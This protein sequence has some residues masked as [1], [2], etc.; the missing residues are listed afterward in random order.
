ML[1]R[2]APLR[3]ARKLSCAGLR[4]PEAASRRIALSN[5][6]SARSRFSRAFCFSRSLSRFAWSV[7]RPPYSRCQ[8]DDCRCWACWPWKPT[9]AEVITRWVPVKKEVQLQVPAVERKVEERC[10]QCRHDEEDRPLRE[11]VGSRCP[12]YR[13]PQ[14]ASRQQRHFTGAEIVVGP[15][16]LDRAFGLHR[17]ENLAAFTDGLD[18][19]PHVLTADMGHIGGV[20]APLLAV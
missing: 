2:L 12:S 6:A 19:E 11:A 10:C 14:H 15:D 18:G 8:R 1:D 4:Q 9:C 13:G 7:R 5:S 17:A 16:D 3:R 20:V